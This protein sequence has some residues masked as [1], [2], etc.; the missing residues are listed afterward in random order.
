MQ[1]D[2]SKHCRTPL[3]Y[4][5]QSQGLAGNLKKKNG[6]KNPNIF[7]CP[8]IRLK[9][10]RK[11]SWIKVVIKNL[12]ILIFHSPPLLLTLLL[13]IGARGGES[14]FRIEFI[15]WGSLSARGHWFWILNSG[16]QPSTVRINRSYRRKQMPRFFIKACGQCCSVERQLQSLMEADS[17]KIAWR[18][19][20][21]M[22]IP[23]GK[24]DW[25]WPQGTLA[26]YTYMNL[27]TLLILNSQTGFQTVT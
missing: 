22:E 8:Q 14:V 12:L 3:G 10:I 6:Q 4:Y 1:K 27:Y 17:V 19:G 25:S 21:K 2:E 26:L 24:K 9:I 5:F 23:Q 15:I 13:R 16:P 7:L 18:A 20:G 11:D